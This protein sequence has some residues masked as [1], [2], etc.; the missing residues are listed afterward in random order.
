MEQ[1]VRLLDGLGERHGVV[2]RYSNLRSPADAIKLLC[3]NSPAFHRELIEA[4][5]DGV[6]Y[7]VIQGGRAI[8]AYEDLAL[9]FG[10][11]DLYI[12][13]VV[14]GS[15]GNVGK[16]LGFIALGVGLVAF[17]ILTAGAG[18]GF[19]GLGAGATKAGLFA[20]ANVVSTIAGGIGLSMAIS[21]V[22]S[23]VAP[24]PQMP[25]PT[26]I[27]RLET[28][29]GASGDNIRATGARGLSR[30]TNQDQSYLY[31]GAKNSSG[32]GAIVPVV[33]GKVLIGSHLLSLDVIPYDTASSGY[34][35]Q[36]TAGGPDQVS[37]KTDY[38]TNEYEALGGTLRT[39]S[40]KDD[41]LTHNNNQYGYYQENDAI[42]GG[43][44]YHQLV[45]Q[46]T[47]ITFDANNRDAV[48]GVPYDLRRNRAY[49]TYN[50]EDDLWKTENWEIVFRLPR[51]L[52]DF[53]SPNSSPSGVMPSGEGKQP[54]YIT[55]L[56][57]LFAVGIYG[58]S[59][60]VPV[61]STSATVTAQLDATYTSQGFRR[62]FTWAHSM[63]YSQLDNVIQQNNGDLVTDN[64]QIRPVLTVT[65]FQ[66]RGTNY[67]QLQ[68]V[69]T[70]YKN[71]IKA[72]PIVRMP[73][74]Q[75]QEH[76]SAGKMRSRQFGGG[77]TVL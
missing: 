39:R 43:N 11:K 41:Q 59:S 3:L 44:K 36:V 53:V 65:D 12:V 26:G 33:F 32:P 16:S 46:D 6:G 57:E 77:Y 24:Q 37:I 42:D 27:R 55:Y 38:I 48:I 58:N 60:R 76:D 18:A 9:P 30:A 74:G 52:F 29:G 13:P 61:G 75:W 21:G 40:I 69:Q 35:T 50:D 15:G 23:L 63:N 10:S 5:K 45:E 71:V 64:I 14:I 49:G 72:G 19:L 22:T 31:T 4:H 67:F 2:H 66:L 28:R 70:G 25:K 51:G 20:G 73:S 68:V 54:G 62:G 7:Q 17:S 56:I 47:V 34:V 8:G 1:T